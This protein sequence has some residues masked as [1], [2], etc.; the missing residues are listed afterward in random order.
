MTETASKNKT[1]VL[2]QTVHKNITASVDAIM[3]LMPK[4]KDERLKSDMTVQLSVFEAFASRT[5]KLLAEAGAE[6]A[7][8]GM[9]SKLSARWSSMMSTVRDSTTSHLAQMLIEGATV[10]AN[11]L[12][13]DLREA[14]NSNVSESVLR[15]MRDVCSYEEQLARELKSYL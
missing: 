14:E 8:T 5:A 3:N 4:V 9:L 13:R 7:D 12:L 1:E 6:P 15:L 10:G 2:L 11:A